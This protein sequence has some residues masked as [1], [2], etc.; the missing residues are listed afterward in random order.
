M[1]RFLSILARKAGLI[2]V[3]VTIVRYRRG[4]L[5]VRQ[6]TFPPSNWGQQSL[7]DVVCDLVTDT[8]YMLTCA[9]PGLPSKLEIHN[10]VR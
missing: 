1:I 7:G 4:E 10:A 9:T 5:H 2:R 8:Q 3:R 6:S